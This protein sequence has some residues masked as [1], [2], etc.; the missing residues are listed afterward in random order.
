ML[1]HPDIVMYL[2]FFP[3]AVWILLPL[4]L[5]VIGLSFRLLSQTL[6]VDTARVPASGNRRRDSRLSIAPIAVRVSDGRRS[7]PASLSNISRY[8][9]CLKNLPEQLI[10]TAEKLT[11]SFTEQ[12]TGLQNLRIQPLWMHAEDTGL[13]IGSTVHKPPPQ[14]LEFVRKHQ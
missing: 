11:V 6:F 5:G 2:W 9:L 14:W 3:L 13:A 10:Q 1:Y 8:G 7:A 4:L 12:G